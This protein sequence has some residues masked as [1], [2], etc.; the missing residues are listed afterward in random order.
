MSW[1]Q[2]RDQVVAVGERLA[3]DGD[4]ERGGAGGDEPGA[5][6]GMWG[7]GEV[8]L[9]NGAVGGGDVGGG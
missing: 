9:V 8:G 1:I 3:G 7:K 5:G 2:A 6:G 4:A